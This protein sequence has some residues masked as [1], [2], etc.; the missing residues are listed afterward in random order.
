MSMGDLCRARS[1]DLGV[2]SYS[3]PH[4]YSS[5]KAFGQRGPTLGIRERHSQPQDSQNFCEPLPT[6]LVNLTAVTDKDSYT[7]N[8]TN[9]DTHETV[10]RL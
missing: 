1:D 2:C 6:I 4:A 9:A 5:G 3:T 10:K 7:D 8:G